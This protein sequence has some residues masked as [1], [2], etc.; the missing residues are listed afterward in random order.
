MVTRAGAAAPGTSATRA[1]CCAS[2]RGTSRRTA[3]CLTPPRC[4]GGTQLAVEG[5]SGYRRIPCSL[6]ALARR[7]D[8]ALAPYP[9]LSSRRAPA[10]P[11]RHHR[12][13][14]RMRVA[15]AVVDQDDVHHLVLDDRGNGFCNRGAVVVARDEHGDSG[16][17]ER[18]VRRAPRM[19]RGEPRLR[20]GRLDFRERRCGRRRMAR[21]R[22]GRRLSRAA[23]RRSRPGARRVLVDNEAGDGSGV[24][25]PDGT[26]VVRLSDNRGFAGGANAGLDARVRRRSGARRSAERRPARRGGLRRGARRRRRAKTARPRRA[27]TARPA[28]R[29]QA[30]SSSSQRGFGRHVDG[31]RD[32]LSG[33]CLCISRGAWETGRAVRRGALPLLRGR[34]LVPARPRARAC[35]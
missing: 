10:L 19:A 11:G 15:R 35:R 13:R 1:T 31:A 4:R 18:I 34:R 25:A 9:L 23:S 28:S 26:V 3:C 7:E 14:H 32:Y 30:A 27:S 33:A 21:R 5:A 24:D 17:H 20:G 29:S 2:S 12:P 22:T 6:A 8:A 16:R